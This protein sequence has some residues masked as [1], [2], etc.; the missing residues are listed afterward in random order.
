MR[1]EFVA[2]SVS[3]TEEI[4]GEIVQIIFDEDPD[5]DPMNPRS[6]NVC[7]SISYEFPPCDLLFEWADRGEFGGGIKATFYTLDENYFNVSLLDGTEINVKHAANP[8]T[9]EKIKALLHKEMGGSH[10]A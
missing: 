1:I 4:G 7:A 2:K 8:E 6:K 9:L 5:D 10:N 3:Y